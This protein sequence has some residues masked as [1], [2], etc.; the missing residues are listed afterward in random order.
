MYE[1]DDLI[2]NWIEWIIIF[3]SMRMTFYQRYNMNDTWLYW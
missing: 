1:Y 2:K 3:D